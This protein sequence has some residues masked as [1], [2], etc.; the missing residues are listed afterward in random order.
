MVIVAIKTNEAVLIGTVNSGIAV[1]ILHFY[2]LRKERKIIIDDV[3]GADINAV[4]YVKS[5]N[6]FALAPN[7][8]FFGVILVFFHFINDF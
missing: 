1:T 5:T 6:L 7:T 4:A 3:L 8:Y 2:V